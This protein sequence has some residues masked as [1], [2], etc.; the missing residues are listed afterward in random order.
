MNSTL[1]AIQTIFNKTTTWAKAEIECE[2]IGAH[3]GYFEDLN[4]AQT[5][6]GEF[7]LTDCRLTKGTCEGALWMGAQ[8]VA[9]KGDQNCLAVF[10]PGYKYGDLHCVYDY[11]EYQNYLYRILGFVCT[12]KEKD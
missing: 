6:L 2:S 10:L 5:V 9:D 7:E 3:L 11:A 12:K 1:S 8:R 4:E